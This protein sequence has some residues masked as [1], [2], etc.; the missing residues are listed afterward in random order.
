MD[1]ENSGPYL[2][3]YLY[4]I[5]F[6]EKGEGE[7]KNAGDVCVCRKSRSQSQRDVA[8]P[9]PWQGQETG[10]ETRRGGF[11]NRVRHKPLKIEMEIEAKCAKSE[12]GVLPLLTGVC[13]IEPPRCSARGWWQ[14]SEDIADAPTCS[15]RALRRGDVR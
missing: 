7:N 4:I 13:V 8:F 2:L 11:Q 1:L 15:S 6:P 5:F 12:S 3:F 9:P 10:G 14:I